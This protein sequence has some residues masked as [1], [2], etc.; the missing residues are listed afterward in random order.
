M[1]DFCLPAVRA[2]A[3]RLAEL[4]PL[5]AATHRFRDADAALERRVTPETEHEFCEADDALGVVIRA[6]PPKKED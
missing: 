5:E 3:A 1:G 6:L 2:M 4:A